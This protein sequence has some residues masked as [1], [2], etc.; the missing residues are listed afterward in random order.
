MRHHYK[1]RKLNRNY[2]QRRAL[3]KGLIKSLIIHEEIKTTESK[4]KVIRGI[5]EKLVTKGKEGTLH[6]RRL[7]HAFLQDKKAVNKLVDRLAP[8]FKHRPG[9]FTRIIR[10]GKRR[11]DK[12][13]LVRLELTAKSPKAAATAS[14]Q[15]SLVEKQKTSVLGRL[16]RRKQPTKKE[17]EEVKK[18][19]QKVQK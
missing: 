7:I 16:R 12:A 18:E 6:A 13:M 8:L 11:G 15:A 17:K 5:F 4:A 19:E 3:F 1:K 10:L 9:G 14:P 2:D